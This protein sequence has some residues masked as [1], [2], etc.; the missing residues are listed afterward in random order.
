MCSLLALREPP[1]PIAQFLRCVLIEKRDD[2]ISN[3]PPAEA[4]ANLSLG[5]Q[6]DAGVPSPPRKPFFVNVAKVALRI[7]VVAGNHDAVPTRRF[8]QQQRIIPLGFGRQVSGFG[9]IIAARPQGCRELGRYHYI[10]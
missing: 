2:A 3:F 10:A 9:D 4:A 7:A 1:K 5:D 8:S 6:D